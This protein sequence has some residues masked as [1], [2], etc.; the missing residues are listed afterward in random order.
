MPGLPVLEGIDRRSIWPQTTRFRKYLV[1]NPI[2]VRGT[3]LSP[4][5]GLSLTAPRPPAPIPA[6]NSKHIAAELNGFRDCPSQMKKSSAAG[7]ERESSPEVPP[8]FERPR[9]S[10]PGNRLV[11]PK[12]RFKK[13]GIALGFT[14]VLIGGFLLHDANGARDPLQSVLVFSGAVFLALGL[15]IVSLVVKN[16]RIWGRDSDHPDRP[17]AS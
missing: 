12:G 16:W 8:A 2:T 9:H 7:T 6:R 13:L 17:V 5:D 3:R 10:T 15:A 1:G 11:K 4:C 14:F